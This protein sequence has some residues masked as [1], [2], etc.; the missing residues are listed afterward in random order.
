MISWVRDRVATRWIQTRKRGG[1]GSAATGQ[2]DDDEDDEEDSS[3]NVHL[4]GTSFHDSEDISDDEDEQQNTY[5]CPHSPRQRNQSSRPP[6][7]LSTNNSKSQTNRRSRS[8]KQNS[9]LEM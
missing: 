3:R 7:V 4:N 5:T 1:D 9:K 6:D 8:E 2:T